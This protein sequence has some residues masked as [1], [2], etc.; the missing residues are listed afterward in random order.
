LF[1]GNH[2]SGK[3][4]FINYLL[5]REVQTTGVAP[6]D[7]AFTMIAPGT[8]DRNQDGPS[9]VGNPDLGLAGLRQFGPTL[10]H[11][12]QYKVRSDVKTHDMMVIDTPGMMDAPA[13]MQAPKAL[14][15]GYD[16]TGVV[17]WL[18]QRADVVCLFFDPDKPGTT[19]ETLQV[20][21]HALGGMD[22]K[23]L[24]ILNKA[25][26]FHKLHDFARAYGSLCWNLSKVMPRKDLPRIY[27]M[28]LPTEKLAD[29]AALRDL[30]AARD[31]VAAEVQAAPSRRMDHSLSELQDSVTQL[32]LQ[33][34]VLKALQQ[35]AS[36]LC[37]KNRAQVAGLAG[38]GTVLAGITLYFSAMIPLQVPLGI[39]LTTILGSSG[40]WWYNNQQFQAWQKQQST[41]EALSL[42][43]NQTHARVVQNADEYMAHW[44]VST[45]RE[46]L[47]QALSGGNWYEELPS[48]S[49][50][51]LDML[52]RMEN[53]EI[54]SLRR[55][56][57]PPHASGLDRL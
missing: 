23:L 12:L 15:R 18:A 30:Q 47:Q 50:S 9:L 20:M 49:S 11:H 38:G 45:V 42:T 54:P 27:T 36:R 28:C 35:K 21:L 57:S 24:I 26:Q 31:Q 1:V 32:Y 7:D 56:A 10:V 55:Q 40:M 6:T 3:S 48:V 22:H 5:G 53:D 17:R 13:G 25:D 37:W 2:S 44:W 14:D 51:D 46:S 34:S 41:I 19:G 39:A 16:F 8:Q 52:Q 33:A 4:S 43:F 29:N